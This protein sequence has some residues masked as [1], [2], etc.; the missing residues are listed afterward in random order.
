MICPIC[1]RPLKSLKSI[2]IGIGPVCVRKLEN[3]NDNADGNQ[4]EMELKEK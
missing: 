3:L 4:L 1:N 2:A